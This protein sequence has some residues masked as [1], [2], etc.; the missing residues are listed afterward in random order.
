MLG[1]YESNIKL[2]YDLNLLWDYNYKEILTAIYLILLRNN[3]S[4]PFED[5]TPKDFWVVWIKL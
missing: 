5:K 4:I 2:S 1:I 3:I